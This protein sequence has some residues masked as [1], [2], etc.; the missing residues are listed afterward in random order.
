M[1]ATFS[2]LLFKECT[3]C[4]PSH[5]RP[6]SGESGEEFLHLEGIPALRDKSPYQMPAQPPAAGLILPS[7]ISTSAG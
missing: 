6:S 1:D 4:V 7:L 5:L 2:L 3:A